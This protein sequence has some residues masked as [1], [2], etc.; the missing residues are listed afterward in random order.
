M[1][2]RRLA[3][4]LFVSMSAVVAVQLVLMLVLA[5]AHKPYMTLVAGLTGTIPGFVIASLAWRGRL[6]S[7]CKPSS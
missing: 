7:A 2:K 6:P 4:I 1:P 5:G 3:L